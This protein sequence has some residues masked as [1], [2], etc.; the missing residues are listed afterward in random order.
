MRGRTGATQLSDANTLLAQL[1]QCRGASLL[2]QLQQKGDDVA[3]ALKRQ[4][5]EYTESLSALRARS[6]RPSNWPRTVA[7]PGRPLA[8]GQEPAVRARARQDRA[9]VQG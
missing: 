7:A 2:A 1:G 9:K 5:E 4:E 6:T 3:A 8:E